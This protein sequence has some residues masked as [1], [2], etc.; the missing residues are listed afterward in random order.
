MPVGLWPPRWPFFQGTFARAAL[1]GAATLL[2]L[3][4][5]EIG[6]R[7]Q[8]HRPVLALEDWRSARIE[9]IRFG[10]R[11]QFDAALGWVPRD[12]FESPG[13]NTLDYGIRRNLCETDVRTDG[14]L[15]VGD[16][17]TNGGYEVA[18]GETWPAHLER[19]TGQPVLNAGVVGYAADQIIL[20]A[21]Q[22]L[23]VLSPNTLVVGIYE[24]T[25]ART[26]FASYG[27]PRPYFTIDSGQLVPHLPPR[28]DGTPRADLGSGLRAALGH[29][30]VLDAVL[31]RTAPGYW[32]GKAIEPVHR[33][34]ET[35]PVA[36]TC[37]LLQRLKARAEAQGVR[38]LLLLQ[39]ARKTL[40][41]STVPDED[42]RQVAACAKT[43][44]LATI[45]QFDALRPA[46]VER[47][48]ILNELYLT[49]SDYGQ[50]SS[51]GNRATAELI[52]A[53]LAKVAE[54]RK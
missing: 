48:A 50:M 13:Y 17:F 2:A 42:A 41:E 32:L 8:T 19:L 7:L 1:A 25:I 21:E 9:G 39:H 27:R 18:D 20:R 31:G 29:S 49:A 45:D 44:G 35:A 40:A 37:A 43:M 26:R 46:V 15:A 51:K 24:E 22:L 52:A 3:P 33:T 28:L 47:P 12:G 16:V 54:S 34:D 36:V 11:G 30:A 4:V 5:L 53:A 6:Y 10:E 23:P 14:I 38:V